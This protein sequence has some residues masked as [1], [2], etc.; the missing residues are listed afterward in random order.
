[1]TEKKVKPRR[2]TKLTPEERMQELLSLAEAAIQDEGLAKI[3][4]NR[5]VNE[6]SFSRGTFFTDIPNKEALYAHLAIKGMRQWLEI[7]AKGKDFQGTARE[8]FL[9]LH[10][11][12]MIFIK[13]HPILY[14]CIY[15]ANLN[16]I[17]VELDQ[18]TIERLDK[19][20]ELLIDSI[21]AC[22]KEAI[23]NGELQ[24]LKDFTTRD[25]ATF[26]WAGQ[27]GVNTLSMRYKLESYDL[28]LKYKHYIRQVLDNMPWHPISTEHDFE[29]TAERIVTEIYGKEFS[30]AKNLN[31]SWA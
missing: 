10:V 18:E 7:I 6:C 20:T 1:M 17:R 5:L 13:T 19:K 16:I 24:P 4:L 2:K 21:E 28:G 29:K 11:A 3:S 14:E 30:L 26:M 23:S 9:V 12:H 31:L 22:I 15:I 25:S 8:R 27:Y